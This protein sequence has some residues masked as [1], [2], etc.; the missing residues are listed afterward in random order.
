MLI[1]GIHP[2]WHDSAAVLYDDYR[3]VA[4]VQ[5]ERLTRVKGD[6]DGIPDA[7]IDE[8]LAIA[9]I[10]RREVDAVAMTRG[11]FPRPLLRWGLL[12]K[13]RMHLPDR[14]AKR[15]KS[16]EG[17][18]QAR[19]EPEAI[20]LLNHERFRAALGFRPDCRLF[21]CN[22]HFAHALPALFFTD[23]DEALVYTADGGGD[24]V[25]YS[26]RRLA[27]GRLDTLFGDDRELLEPRRIDS[28]GMAY[29]LA[30]AALGFRMLRHEG[31]LTGLAAFGRPVLTEEMARHFRVDEAGRI[32]SDY[33]DYGA[34]AEDI[35]RMAGT[36][37]REDMAAS[38]QKLLE[39]YVLRALR[40]L[41]ER[42]GT[43]RLALAGG[44]FANVRLNR[45]LAEGTGC[46]E[47][48]VFPAM[49]DEG[50]AAGAPL[51]FLL[52]RD[53]LAPWLG[54]RTRLADVSLG[55]DYDGAI[56]RR[57]PQRDSRPC[58]CRGRF[59]GTAARAGFVGALYIGRM[60]TARALSNRSI[61]AHPAERSINAELNAR[62]ERSEFMPFAPVV[63]ACD[64]G[65][66]F[67]VSAV[68]AY[69][70]AS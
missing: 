64:A 58:G 28:L 56:G 4:A 7:A 2:A 20:K 32:D 52:A 67:A 34:M 17:Q 19:E 27:A 47:V 49:G 29:G 21:F 70:A 22:H 51:E 53:G 39:D 55:R 26:A 1:L 30:T 41:L 23:W 13:I 3:L 40:L 65:E 57:W 16:I 37:S 11:V 62:L 38:I 31:K 43:R 46:E 60:K 6:G 18:M 15:P 61:L 12:Q 59:R 25:Q 50:L 24:N 10:T 36:V 14:R 54:K 9:A 48:F 69:P 68:N 45:L 44:V 35:R 63:A 42:E 5:T 8:V 33:A 66:V